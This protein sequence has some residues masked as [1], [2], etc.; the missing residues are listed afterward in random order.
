[1]KFF[2][3]VFGVD[4]KKRD[5]VMKEKPL[6]SG[7]VE[8]LGGHKAYPKSILTEVFFYEDRF[9]IG[10][11]NFTIYYSKIKDISNSKDRKRHDDWAAFGLVG[12][13]FW[14]KDHVHT[15]IEYDD[16]ADI[17]KIVLDFDNN[18]NYAQGLIYKKMLEARNKEGT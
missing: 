17:Q 16:G 8:Y 4:R 6:D 12:Y 1:M 11:Y 2:E 5:S 9:V 14:K 3:K 15:M 10:T 13:L 7:P 18:A